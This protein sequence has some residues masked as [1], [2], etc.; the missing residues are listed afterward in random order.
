MSAMAT[1]APS[2]RYFSAKPRPIPRAAPVMR[3]DFPFNLVMSQSFMIY[4]APA[5]A[6]VL[7]IFQFVADILRPAS[8]ESQRSGFSV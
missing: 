4:F 2:S 3:A 1:V 5:C 7:R 6:T 8:A